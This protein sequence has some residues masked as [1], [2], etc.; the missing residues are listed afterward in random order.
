MGR[1]RPASTHTRG[2]PA[3]RGAR[4]AGL[5]A[6][7]KPTLHPRNRHRNGY[8]F[9]LL[10]RSWP[11]LAP[12]V[13]PHAHGD[14]SIDFAEPA[15][16][17]ALNQALLAHD[18]HV[19][20][21]DLPSGYLCPPVPG[22]ADYLHHL[23]DLLASDCGGQIPRGAAIA[24]LDIGVGANVI[25][26]IIAVRDY[27]WRM[28]GAET[29]EGALAAAGRIVAANPVLI[30]RIELR[31][32]PNSEHVF[33]GI[34]RSGEQFAFTVCNPP[35]H[36]S[37]AEAAAGT[38]R[39]LRNLGGRPRSLVRN[40]GGQP[41]EL[42]CPGGELGFIQRMIRESR[43]FADRCTWF[44]TLVAKSAHLPALE[45][46]L[47]RAQACDVRKLAMAQG[48]KQS[49]I[50]AWTFLR[51]EDRR[52]RFASRGEPGARS[53]ARAKSPRGSSARS[54]ERSGQFR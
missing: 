47:T 34:V 15:A 52:R 9:V 5:T 38:R 29:D 28:V 1:D 37:R 10:A 33:Q 26:P 40:F 18:Y 39:K 21:W 14:L 7:T 8:D 27:D 3:E 54:P 30:G 23:A 36:A 11:A 35:F 19:R 53:S 25:Y 32:Q 17:K 6:Q 31:R 50:L 4:P 20:A 2:S 48:Q 41:A 12:F 51:P 42:W 45:H 24:G 13:R 16:V 43:A 46:A 22:R 49:R 44:T